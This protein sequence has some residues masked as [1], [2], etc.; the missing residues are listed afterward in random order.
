[1]QLCSMMQS[2]SRNIAFLFSLLIAAVIT[3][4]VLSVYL[5]SENRYF[6]STNK[7]LILQNDSIMSVNIELESALKNTSRNGKAA[8]SLNA[9]IRK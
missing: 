5:Y 3:L 8:M 9:G 6:K 1:M 7:S 4:A 2:F